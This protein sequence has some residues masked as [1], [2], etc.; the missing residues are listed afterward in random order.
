[1]AWHLSAAGISCPHQMR[2]RS[3]QPGK[4]EMDGRCKKR[5]NKKNQPIGAI[6]VRSGPAHRLVP[7]QNGHVLAGDESTTLGNFPTRRRG[8]WAGESPA[9][10]QPGRRRLSLSLQKAGQESCLPTT[11]DRWTRLERAK[12]GEVALGHVG[13]SNAIC[14][15]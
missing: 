3:P 7:S 12:G 4:W 10:W 11:L 14:G 15:C 1:M 9:L 8:L 2:T 6:A 13:R 5:E